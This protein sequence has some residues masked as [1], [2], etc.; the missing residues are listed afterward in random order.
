MGAD[1]GKTGSL[2]IRTFLEKIGC[3]FVRNGKSWHI[4]KVMFANTHRFVATALPGGR[5]EIQLPELEDGETVEIVVRRVDRDWDGHP[6]IDQT[7]DPRRCVLS[8]RKI[9]EFLIS[10]R[11]VWEG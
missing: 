9:E 3:R 7:P 1:L 8:P 11:M 4:L 5:V 10:E 2:G 6:D